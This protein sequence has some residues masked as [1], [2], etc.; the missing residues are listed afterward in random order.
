MKLRLAPAAAVAALAAFVVAGCGG[1]GSSGGDVA[2]LAPP[3]APIFVEGVLRPSGELKSNTDAIA[4]QVAGIDDLGELVV[5][6]LE[7]S[8]EAEG[9]G[10]DY[11]KEVEPWL[12]ERGGVF[13]ERLE[14]GDP[15][16]LGMVVETTDAD[17]TQEFIEEQ[18]KASSH[19]HHEASYEGVDYELGGL[20][21]N[22]AIGV[23][24]DFLV[25]AEGEKVFEH[26]VVASK[27]FKRGVGKRC[28]A[29]SFGHGIRYPPHVGD[30]RVL[31]AMPICPS[32]GIHR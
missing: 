4:K 25:M 22:Q 14:D 10:F 12:G 1:E 29:D 31:V 17:A 11:E 13:F 28:R 20:E 15:A 8:A 30:R 32:N 18:T 27:L 7:S 2:S 21:G 26:L 24:G 5:S 3:G 6:E 9:E 16:G 19:P 23:V